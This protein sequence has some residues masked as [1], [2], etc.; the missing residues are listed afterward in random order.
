M[1]TLEEFKVGS[2]RTSS[3]ANAFKIAFK[4]EHGRYPTAQEIE[5]FFTIH[6]PKTPR[7]KSH[8]D[9]GTRKRNR[10]HRSRSY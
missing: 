6:A 9:K 5:D 7:T 3:K 2:G 8:H 10:S 4:K 1:V